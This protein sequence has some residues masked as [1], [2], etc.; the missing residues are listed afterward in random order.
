MCEPV[1]AFDD[2]QNAASKSK[3]SFAE[4]KLV[5]TLKHPW[6][7]WRLAKGGDPEHL[8]TIDAFSSRIARECGIPHL[9]RYFLISFIHA[10]GTSS[11][12]LTITSML[13]L[14]P[15][16]LKAEGSCP[17]LE[18]G[19]PDQTDSRPPPRLVKIK[20]TTNMR[21]AAFA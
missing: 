19:D 9:L 8:S 6:D 1:P 14:S 4:S 3:H 15:S 13:E 10:L 2:I 11:F 16:D 7:S 21:G 20:L 12:S 17:C 18:R 5:L